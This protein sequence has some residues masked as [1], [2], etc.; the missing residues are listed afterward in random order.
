MGLRVGLNL[1]PCGLQRQVI[2]IFGFVEQA[3]F[4]EITAC[5]QLPPAVMRVDGSTLLD[6][7]GGTIVLALD[8]KLLVEIEAIQRDVLFLGLGTSN[9]QFQVVLPA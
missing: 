4:L 6:I 2:V 5:V 1:L 9:A 7:V 3:A 8:N